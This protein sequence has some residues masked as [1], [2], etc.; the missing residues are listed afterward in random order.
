MS[1]QIY[2]TRFPKQ[3][4]FV[5]FVLRQEWADIH[6]VKLGDN[7]AID[8]KIISQWCRENISQR[9]SRSDGNEVYYFESLADATFFRLRWTGSVQETAGA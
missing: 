2:R 5:R 1:E 3:R 9:W 7:R 4:D 8:G 6:R